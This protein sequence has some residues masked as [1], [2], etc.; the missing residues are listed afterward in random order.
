MTR[1]QSL[2]KYSKKYKNVIRNDEVVGSTPIG[3]FLLVT[4]RANSDHAME[5]LWYA[6]RQSKGHLSQYCFS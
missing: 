6:G 1:F 3:W 2:V 4:D 5:L